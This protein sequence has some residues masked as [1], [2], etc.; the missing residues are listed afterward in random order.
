MKEQKILPEKEIK[1]WVEFIPK[2]NR[3]K[4]EDFRS[5]RIDTPGWNIIEHKGK[6]LFAVY[7]DKRN[8]INSDSHGPA[9]VVLDNIDYVSKEMEKVNLSGFKHLKEYFFDNLIELSEERYREILI[10]STGSD[11]GVW[12]TPTERKEKLEKSLPK[13]EIKEWIEFIP[14]ENH[15]PISGYETRYQFKP[16]W[17]LIYDDENGNK[18]MFCAYYDASCDDFINHSGPS[19][20][21]LDNI[22]VVN[23][24]MD[25]HD[26][27]PF[28]Y[29]KEY[30]TEMLDFVSL[31]EFKKETGYDFDKLY[32]TP[33]GY[34]KLFGKQDKLSKNPLSKKEIEQWHKIIPEDHFLSLDNFAEENYETEEDGWYL[35][36]K[37]SKSS[38]LFC[39]YQECGIPAKNSNGPVYV[40]L[41]D[42]LE[43]L[44]KMMTER[45]CVPFIAFK[46]FVQ[47]NLFFNETKFRERMISKNGTDKDVWTT[48]KEYREIQKLKAKEEEGDNKDMATPK[49]TKTSTGLTSEQK[50]HYLKLAEA[51]GAERVPSEDFENVAYNKPYIVLAGENALG[52]LKEEDPIAIIYYSS[53]GDI[54]NLFGPALID[55]LE[56]KELEEDF[57]E[58]ISHHFYNGGETK[59]EYWLDG[60]N[61]TLSAWKKNAKARIENVLKMGFVLPE[62]CPDYLVPD[63]YKK[64]SSVSTE[65]KPTVSGSKP[66][67][68]GFKATVKSDLSAV[69]TRV[70]VKKSTELFSGL[71]VDFLA[72]NKKGSEATAMKKK[73][74]DL[75][76]TED[77]K[78]AFQILIGALL[79]LMTNSDKIPE[80]IKDVMETVGKGFRTDGM[81]HFAVEF[82]DYLSGPGAETFRNTIVK[83][84]EGF[85]KLDDMTNEKGEINVR[86][87]AEPTLSLLT[88]TGTK[89][90]EKNEEELDYVETDVGA[91]KAKL[92]AMRKN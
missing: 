17:Y 81:T 55:L 79:P 62:T 78:A 23:K 77:G 10:D 40:V 45:D 91:A 47:N 49:K 72:S 80:S 28:K 87:I 51:A 15:V 90:T 39:F 89:E 32:D 31:E 36:A 38:P 88:M 5:F 11:A 59:E 25:K 75:L 53:E 6:P 42:N 41:T 30:S 1:E 64:P 24:F 84:F 12:T 74:K 86:A 7:C 48:P 14:K 3:A 54:H 26:Y 69:A 43:E 21:A 56:G 22:D 83:A 63:G 34:K 27:E 68:G 85:K 37:D 29:L 67:S 66:A 58:E 50:E 33:N 57:H 76:S 60:N 20:I 19:H 65:K 70:A 8:T 82:V 92:N 71:I 52:D 35:V 46:E 4:L 16:G 18:P 13:E 61:Y 9:Y 44:N 2:E 73:V